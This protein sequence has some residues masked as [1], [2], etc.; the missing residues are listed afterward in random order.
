M[1]GAALCRTECGAG[2]DGGEGGTVEMV[3][4]GGALRPEER[5]PDAGDG[6][7]AE[8]MERDGVGALSC[9]RGIGRGGDGA[10]ALDAHGA[11]A[12]ES[13][14]CGR[15][16]EV[17]FASAG[18]AKGRPTQEARGGFS[19]EE[20]GGSRLA[21]KLGYVPSVPILVR[22]REGREIEMGCSRGSRN[23]HPFGFAQG[24]L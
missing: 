16:G 23:P 20:L 9:G 8:A 5:R 24:R 4:R 11:A 18:S 10:A 21:G 3:K 12:G 1:G 14:F 6:T 17:N 19:A 7:V 13:G 22:V 2:G 15:A